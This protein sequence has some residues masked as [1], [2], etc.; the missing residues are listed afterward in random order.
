MKAATKGLEITI[1]VRRKLKNKIKNKKNKKKKETNR[2]ERTIYR[3][4]SAVY[5][6]TLLIGNKANQ[7]APRVT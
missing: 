6:V 7:C 1:S 3:A 4:M 2:K 5:E